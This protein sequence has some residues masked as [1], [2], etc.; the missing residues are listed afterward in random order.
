MPHPRRRWLGASCRGSLVGVGLLPAGQAP[1]TTLTEGGSLARGV[2]AGVD[3]PEDCGPVEV[4]E[5]GSGLAFQKEAE[6]E[7]VARRRPRGASG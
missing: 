4:L 1:Q 7:V 3:A 2:S 5:A 6:P